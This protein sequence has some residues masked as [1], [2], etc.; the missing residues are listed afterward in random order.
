MKKRTARGLVGWG[1]GRERESSFRRRRRRAV[2]GRKRET[3]RE[4]PDVCRI[5]RTGPRN[6]SKEK[7]R[8]LKKT[9]KEGKKETQR[10]KEESLNRRHTQ[11]DRADCLPF[12]S[13]P[14]RFVLLQS[15]F[16][17]LPFSAWTFGDGKLVIVLEKVSA[18]DFT[19]EVTLCLQD[20]PL[21]DQQVSTRMASRSSSRLAKD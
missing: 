20:F 8:F 19:S 3:C 14:G 15:P 13:R 1:R 2:D 5:F 9:R 10:E 17:V 16:R 7:V 6:F 21:A 4:K 18:L 12:P 11:P